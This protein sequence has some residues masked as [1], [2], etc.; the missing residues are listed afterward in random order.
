MCA[1]I[2]KYLIVLVDAGFCSYHVDRGPRDQAGWM[3]IDWSLFDIYPRIYEAW[4]TG[5]KTI[6]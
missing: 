1:C 5:Y 3:L 4:L 6:V 2:G